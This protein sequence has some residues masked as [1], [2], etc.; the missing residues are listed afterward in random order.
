[1]HACKGVV[2]HIVT[3]CAEFHCINNIPGCVNLFLSGNVNT[4]FFNIFFI[5]VNKGHINRNLTL[6]FF[7]LEAF[8]N[9][10]Y[11]GA[12]NVAA[13][14]AA[15]YIFDSSFTEKSNLF[16]FAEGESIVDILEKNHTF[17]CGFS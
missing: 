16:A 3:F 13:A 2:G 7:I 1:M 15:F 17:C 4:F 5:E 8:E 11:V 14:T 9:V 10:F 6:F 12:M